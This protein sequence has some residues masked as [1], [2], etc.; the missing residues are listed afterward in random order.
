M[1]DHPEVRSREDMLAAD[2]PAIPQMA[3]MA[4]AVHGALLTAQMPKYTPGLMHYWTL[5]QTEVWVNIQGHE[6]SL[7]DMSDD[8]LNRVIWHLRD[9]SHWLFA[10][11]IFDLQMRSADDPDDTSAREQ[12]DA[13]RAE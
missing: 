5:N 7:G 13:L 11:T 2:M 1:I 9:K 10:D 4:D 8:Y 6:I 3:K 12:L